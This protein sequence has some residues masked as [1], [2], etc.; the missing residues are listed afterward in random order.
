MSLFSHP[1]FDGHEEVAFFHDPQS[2]L[3]AIAAIHN[4]NRGPALGGCRMWPYESDDE[5][6]T[7]V[8]RL[9]RGMTYKSALAGL[10]YGGGKSVI[11]GDSR[12]AK[13]P[14]LFR[15]MGR[16]VETL[17]GRYIIAE[18]VGIS[19][20]DVEIMGRETRHVAGIRAGGGGDGAGDP[21]PAT[22]YGVYMGIRAAVKRRLGRDRLDGLAVAV[23]GL[24]HVG[25]H[26]CR[27]LAGDGARLLV[28]DLHGPSV[29]RV[30][31]DF[32][33]RAVEPEAIYEAEAE[34]F[35]PC[36]LGAAINDETLD[37]LRAP[38]VAGSA[39]NQLAEPCH[40]A[41]LRRR[42][43]LYAPDY[44]INAGGVIY[45]SHEGPRFDRERAM[46]HVAG[47][48]D[49]LLEIFARA[50]A[51]GLPTSEAADRLAEERFHKA[52]APAHAAA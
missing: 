30:V 35:A 8:L 51:H 50:E 38:I 7:D 44:V 40:G 2:G 10:D 3:K 29:D 22:A 45:I 5:A 31:R 14:A 12:H 39:N 17:G 47:I 41:E 15:A 16:F 13:S 23:Q 25:W 49:T 24:G 37:R 46:A 9:S 6:L 28:T 11:I 26:L 52:N 42:G 36:A 43:I 4:L 34:V 33:A 32:G 21:S 27:L 19:V 48:H 20:E 18:D 1:E